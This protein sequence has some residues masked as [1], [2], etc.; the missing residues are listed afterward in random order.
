MPCGVLVEPGVRLYE[1]GNVT[2]CL[3]TNGI[4]LFSFFRHTH[5]LFGMCSYDWVHCL[6]L[7]SSSNSAFIELCIT[8]CRS[9]SI[10][11]GWGDTVYSLLLTILLLSVDSP[12]LLSDSIVSDTCSYLLIMFLPLL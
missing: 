7:L 11:T 2:I 3:L 10:T 6:I 8:L 4:L 5:L 1:G 9:S 12:R